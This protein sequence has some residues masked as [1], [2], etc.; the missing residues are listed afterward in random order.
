MEQKVVFVSNNDTELY[1]ALVKN[2]SIKICW[3]NSR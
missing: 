2:R 1:Q 3:I